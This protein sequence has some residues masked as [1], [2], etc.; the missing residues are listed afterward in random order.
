MAPK[1]R[2]LLLAASL[3]LILCYGHRFW[4]MA[5]HACI[6]LSTIL[7]VWNA[8]SIGVPDHDIPFQRSLVSLAK[9]REQPFCLIW[10]FTDNV[11]SYK[12]MIITDVHSI[13]ELDFSSLQ[14]YPMTDVDSDKGNDFATCGRTGRRN[15]L[16]DILDANHAT[17]STASLPLEMQKLHCKGEAKAAWDVLR[18]SS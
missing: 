18:D 17:T 15:A 11:K 1:S 5:N 6:S 4:Y 10:Y 14:P 7:H 9:Y 13:T 2:F 3:T 16:A 8:P 12:G